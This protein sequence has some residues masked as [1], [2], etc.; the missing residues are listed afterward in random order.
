MNIAN[1]RKAFHDYFIEERFEAGMV[2]QG[3]EVK[4][5]K[6]A[7]VQ[8]RDSYVKIKDQEIWLLGCHV[9]PMISTSSHVHVDSDRLKKLLLKTRE[10]NLLMGKVEQKG[11]SII[12]LNLHLKNGLIKAEIALAKGKKMYDKRSVEKEKEAIRDK[13]QAIKQ[14]KRL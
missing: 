12:V 6:E 11:Y 1:N 5:I 4:S 2:L 10:I 9:T 8:L 3:W 7:R 13:A 14:L